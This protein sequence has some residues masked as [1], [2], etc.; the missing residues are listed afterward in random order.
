MKVHL[1]CDSFNSQ[2]ARVTLFVNGANTGQLTLNI[3]ETIWL[4]HILDKGCEALSPKNEIP[5]TFVASGDFPKPS[6][7]EL[8][9]DCPEIF[10]P[11]NEEETFNE[12]HP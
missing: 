5:F 1:R 3:G 2:H 8:L 11:G 12:S 10:Q 9:S 7:E 4:H 6:A